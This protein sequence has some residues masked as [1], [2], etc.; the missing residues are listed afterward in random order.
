MTPEDLNNVLF[1]LKRT[2]T[3][4]LQEAAVLVD[5]ARKVVELLKGAPRGQ[6]LSAA[7]E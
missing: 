4:N 3:D 5:L 1:F 6:D 7:A 2:T